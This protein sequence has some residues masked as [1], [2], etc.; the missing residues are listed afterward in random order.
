MSAPARDNGTIYTIRVQPTRPVMR[1]HHRG[2][3]PWINTNWI[4]DDKGIKEA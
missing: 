4:D 3:V 2:E 1:Q